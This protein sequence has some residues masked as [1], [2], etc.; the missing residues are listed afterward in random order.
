MS[1]WER[2]TSETYVGYASKHI[3]PLIGTVQV[4]ALDAG[5]GWADQRTD[6]RGAGGGVSEYPG[7]ARGGARGGDPPRRRVRQRVMPVRAGACRAS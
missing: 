1:T 3:R 6:G 7:T 5:T 4:G 2:S